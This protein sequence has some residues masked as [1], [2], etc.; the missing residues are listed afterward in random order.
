MA[1]VLSYTMAG[2]SKPVGFAYGQGLFSAP[3]AVFF[4]GINAMHE[5]NIF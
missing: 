4:A 3:Y 2:D 5:F 1:V